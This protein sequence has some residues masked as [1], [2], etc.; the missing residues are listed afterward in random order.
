MTDALKNQIVEAANKWVEPGNDNRSQKKLSKRIGI[1]DATLSNLRKGKWDNMGPGI[2][3]KCIAFFKSIGSIKTES[4]DVWQYFD[5]TPEAETIADVIRNAHRYQRR[6]AIDGP[7]G[8]GKTETIKH[9]VNADK[10]NEIIH[11]I[12]RRS[13]NPKTFCVN[14][15]EQL[16]L[17]QIS[18]NRYQL[19]EDIA[20]KLLSMG[21]PCLVFDELE[22]LSFTCYSSIKTIVDLTDG[23]CG[24]VMVGIDLWKLVHANAVK[25][26]DAFRQIQRRFPVQSYEF[27]PEGIDAEVMKRILNDCGIKNKYA[28]EWFEENVY[29]YDALKNTVKDALRIARK[30]K[31]EVIDREFLSH[32]FTPK[33]RKSY[34]KDQLKR[35]A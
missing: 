4:E 5:Y 32:L 27:L 20:E 19:E 7:T 34:R 15:A 24:I 10:T 25:G 8:K 16:G 2:W 33:N 11:I 13:M 31:V 12:G 30:N 26:K 17:S 3:N 9:L 29:D 6:A 28:H 1:S 23:Q 35:A 14:I 22:N 21:N 18:S